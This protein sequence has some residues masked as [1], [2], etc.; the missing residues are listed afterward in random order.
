MEWNGVGLGV[1]IVGRVGRDSLTRHLSVGLVSSF[2]FVPLHIPRLRFSL[3]RTKILSGA[4][5][6]GRTAGVELARHITPADD[7]MITT[8]A[9][10]VPR[11]TWIG[12]DPKVERCTV[13]LL[14]GFLISNFVLTNWLRPGPA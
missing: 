2:F 7:A 13:H 1:R 9:V 4:A 5:A 8:T 6:D 11:P 12:V 10:A 3:L 14:L